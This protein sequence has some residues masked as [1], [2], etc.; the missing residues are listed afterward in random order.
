MEYRSIYRVHSSSPFLSHQSLP[1]TAPRLMCRVSSVSPLRKK[2]TGLLD[3]TRKIG[4]PMSQSQKGT[5]RFVGWL[6]S[7][8]CLQNLYSLLVVLLEMGT[9][10]PGRAGSRPVAKT[11][12]VHETINAGC[13]R[14]IWRKSGTIVTQPHCFQPY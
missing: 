7:A 5:R 6:P 13:D 1:Q 12:R 2:R 11:L 10:N 9:A 3:A 4:A 8:C 14:T